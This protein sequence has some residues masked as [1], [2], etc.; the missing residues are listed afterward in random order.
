MGDRG[1]DG[2]MASPS[3][4]MSLR[5]PWEIVKEREDWHAPVHGVAKSQT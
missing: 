5:K 2:W 1:Q 3:T 4:D